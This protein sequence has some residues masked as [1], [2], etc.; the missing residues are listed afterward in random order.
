MGLWSKT[1][2]FKPYGGFTLDGTAH[3]ETDNP[4]EKAAMDWLKNAP[5]GVVAEGVGG[6]YSGFAR[7]STHSGQPTVLGWDFHEMQWRGG[8]KE[9]GS[10]FYDI[11]RLYC[12]SNWAET[13]AILRQ[14]NVRYV[15]VGS[16]EL[17]AY[18][19][20]SDACPVG[21]AETKFMRNL[22]VAFQQGIVTIY[23]V[24]YD[25]ANSTGEAIP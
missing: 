9:M 4:D 3:L 15:V 24:P 11:E 25:G 10:R 21:M 8:T 17:S 19:R 2:G 20:G 7:M 12:A 14:Y 16:M 6:S 13:E 23:E 1:G 18:G 22:P 5:L